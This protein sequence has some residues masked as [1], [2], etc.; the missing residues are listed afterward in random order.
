M[1]DAVKIRT[2][3]T[4]QLI[5]KRTGKTVQESVS[6][7]LITDVGEN[8]LAYWTKGDMSTKGYIAYMSLSDESSAA[9]ETETTESGSNTGPRKAVTTSISGSVI[10]ITAEWATAEANY[11]IRR[12]YLFTA[13]SGGYLFATTAFA[14]SFTKTSDYTFK[15]E[16]QITY[17]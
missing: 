12:A 2:K 4:A 9:G 3:V 17:S 11:T 7:N 10:T 13:A 8:M 1:K 16:W 5:D 14:S 15:I 6:R